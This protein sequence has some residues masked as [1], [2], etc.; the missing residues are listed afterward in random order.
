MYCR[1]ERVTVGV[2]YLRPSTMGRTGTGACC[3]GARSVLRVACFLLL[4]RRDLCCAR[5]PVRFQT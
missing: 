1:C 4:R 5:V 2:V 3:V